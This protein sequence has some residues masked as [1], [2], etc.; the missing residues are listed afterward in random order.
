LKLKKLVLV[1]LFTVDNRRLVHFITSCTQ[2]KAVKYG[3]ALQLSKCS[4]NPKFSPE[5]W[6][7]TL[8]QKLPKGPALEVYTGDHWSVS[9]DILKNYAN[10]LWV[11]SAGYGLISAKS[12][13]GAYDA[14]FSTGNQNSVSNNLGLI[15]SSI[16]QNRIWWNELTLLNK[17][18]LSLTELFKRFRNDLFIIA[19]APTYINVVKQEIKES[20]SSRL[21]NEDNLLIITSSIDSELKNFSII[22]KEKVRTHKDIGGSVVSIH[23]RVA[24]QLLKSSKKF[25]YSIANMKVEYLKLEN[26]SPNIVKKP[27]RKL[28]DDE[29]VKII[30]NLITE[31]SDVKLSSSVVLRMFRDKGYSCEQKRFSRLY[32]TAT[33]FVS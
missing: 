28:T 29:I 8:G 23:T 18:S 3:E 11:L 21:V 24:R 19:A 15:S 12:D 25:Q 26:Q 1:V 6:L 14:T 7:R 22:T 31:F 17:N 30:K 4:E 5:Y 16:Q 13:I 2:S 27:I 20:I 10:E 33:R 32:K 9:K